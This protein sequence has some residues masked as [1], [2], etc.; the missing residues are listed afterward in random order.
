MAGANRSQAVGAG[1]ASPCASA[2]PPDGDPCA[3]RTVRART[4]LVNAAR[5]LLKSYGQVESGTQIALIYG[6]TLDAAQR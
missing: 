4:A 1:A 5:G 2:N 6:L 3:C